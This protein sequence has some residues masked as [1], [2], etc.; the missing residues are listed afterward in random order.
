MQDTAVTL[1]FGSKK[2]Y[3]GFSSVLATYCGG[4]GCAFMRCRILGQYHLKVFPCPFSPVVHS[5]PWTAAYCFSS[6][7]QTAAYASV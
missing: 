2:C 3:F 5:H 1:V 7:A 6:C 4:E